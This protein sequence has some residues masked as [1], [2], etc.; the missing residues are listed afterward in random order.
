MHLFHWLE[1]PSL[2]YKFF[3]FGFSFELLICSNQLSICVSVPY[4]FNYVYN[5]CYYLERYY[6]L[7]ILFPTFCVFPWIFF[8]MIRISSLFSFSCSPN[9][10][11][12]LNICNIIILDFHINVGRIDSWFN[13][14]NSRIYF[15]FLF[16]TI[17]FWIQQ[18]VLK[19]LLLFLFFFHIDPEHFCWC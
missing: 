18:E 13:P 3:I 15:D 4:S 11:N 5:V 17:F 1:K 8:C 16:I 12:F 9:P 7:I 2:P 10:V 14:S 6:H 19:V